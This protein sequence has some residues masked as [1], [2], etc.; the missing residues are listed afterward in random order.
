MWRVRGETPADRHAARE[1]V[2]NAFEGLRGRIPGMLRL[3]IGLDHSAVDYAC[4]VVLIADFVSQGALAAYAA[5]P[6][7][8]RV[9]ADLGDLR[10]ERYQVDFV[11]VVG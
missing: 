7:H 5:H 6:E 2:R 8:Q 4:D 3:E 10:V 9:R 1:R 11:V